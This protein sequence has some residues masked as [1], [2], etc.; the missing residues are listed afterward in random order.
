M[1]AS[2][3][4]L[5]A[6]LQEVAKKTDAVTRDYYRG[7]GKHSD[8]AWQ[9][10]FS[11]FEDFCLAAGVNQPS[12]VS[13]I[14]GN[15]WNVFI[16]STTLCSAD[17]VIKYCK[18]DLS[19]WELDRFR[20]KDVSKDDEQKF[21][22]SAFFKKRKNIIEIQ[23]E[24]QALK[25]LA[26]SHS[27][28]PDK[29][30]DYSSDSGNMLEINIPDVHFGKL[31]WPDETGYEPYD[32]KIASVMYQRA[33]RA[34]ID[35][36]KGTKYEQVLY[37]IGNDMLNADDLEGRTT[38]GT[39]V[40]N[41]ARY[42]KVFSVVRTTVIWAIEELRKIAPIKV[43]VVAGNHDQLSSWHLGDSVQCYFHAYKDVIVENS[44]R[45]RK[46]HEFGTVMLG[47]THGDKGSLEDY[48][49]LMATEQPEMFGRTKFREMHTGHTH[50]T[51]L[52]EK[53]G[54]RVRVLPALCPADDWH[55]ENS[56]VGNL[57]NAEAYTWSRKEGL[58]GITIFNDNSQAMLVSEVILK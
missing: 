8:K 28:E 36:T 45:Q 52:D 32:I 18:V 1:S 56:Y 22:I 57:R 26:E 33:V 3:A 31:A 11:K 53:H 5:I 13:E 43:L 4:D 54:V 41:D 37:V 49:L 17:D 25:N 12:A 58:T 51:K 55:S 42:H 6:D 10:H 40:T 50:R 48:P 39:Q 29:E 21:Q 23:K 47:F 15:S 34:L 35:R 20:A 14:N 38:S 24:I 16:P 30:Y 44:P 27:I 7:S 9:K 2:K 46:Y 19:V